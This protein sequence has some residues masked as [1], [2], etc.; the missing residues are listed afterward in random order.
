MPWRFA[1]RLTWGE[2]QGGH[3]S[4]HPWAEC[5][6]LGHG[7]EAAQRLLGLVGGATQRTDSWEEQTPLDMCARQGSRPATM[8]V[9]KIYC[10]LTSAHKVGLTE[11]F[12]HWAPLIATSWNNRLEC[13]E[14][15][16]SGE[17]SAA[18][19]LMG[20][21]WQLL[22]WMSNWIDALEIYLNYSSSDNGS[23]FELMLWSGTRLNCAIMSGVS[24]FT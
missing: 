4:L 12:L 10:V 7:L 18:T 1:W 2:V 24:N 6:S 14:N 20:W 16:T 11:L 15:F 23:G 8:C 19:H 21:L 9:K 3:V 17:K 13:S 22:L 5:R